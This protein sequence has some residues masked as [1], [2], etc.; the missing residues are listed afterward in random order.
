MPCVS[1]RFVPLPGL[2]RLEQREQLQWPLSSA[3]VRWGSYGGVTSGG[4]GPLAAGRYQSRL[5]LQ[6]TM[7]PQWLLHAF[8]PSSR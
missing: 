8:P 3:P 1:A 2:R 5:E 4:N 6:P 7:H